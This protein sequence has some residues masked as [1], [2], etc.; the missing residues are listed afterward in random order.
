[1][2]AHEHWNR[3]YQIKGESDVSWFETRP[4]E[5]LRMI[6]AAG[7]TSESC[8]IDIGGGDSRLV[9]HLAAKGLTCLA[10]LDVSESALERA[11]ARL[12]KTVAV[13]WIAADVTGDWT[14][15]PMDIW[16]DRA[17][18]HFLT[19]DRERAAYRSHLSRTLKPGGS[20]IISTFALDGPTSCSGLPVTRY[21][22]ET[23]SAEL[24]RELELVESTA[25]VHHTPWGSLQP[26]QYSRFRR[27]A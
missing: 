16:H 3:V 5:S 19:R 18:F 9:D 21:S 12:G 14:L 24:G 20:A 25:H 26:F 4:A 15:K 11:R 7:V 6:E 23:L 17:V 8:V 13:T 22:P 2:D 10:V 1:M 27:R